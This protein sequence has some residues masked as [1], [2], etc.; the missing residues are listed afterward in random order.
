MILLSAE[1]IL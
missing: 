1:M